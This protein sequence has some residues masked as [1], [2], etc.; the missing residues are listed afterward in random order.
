MRIGALFEGGRYSNFDARNAAGTFTFGGIDALPGRHPATYRTQRIGEVNTSFGDY[1]FGLYWQDDIRVNR[2]FSF[3]VGVRQ[4]DA[5]AHRDK[6]NVMPRWASHG[7]R[8]ATR[9]RIRGGYG[10]FYDWYDIGLYDQT[11]RVNGVAQRDL[12]ILNP[13]YPEP[14]LGPTR[15]VQPGGRIQA[16][17]GSGDALRPPGV[18]RRRAAVAHEP[19]A[20][21]NYQMLRGRNQMRAVNIN[22]GR[23]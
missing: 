18:D 7:R 1:Q 11:L 23:P 17:S 6:L 20:Q 19:H 2:H 10:M 12:L 3:S 16:A 13:G 9:R 5:V 22:A 8:R 14:V 4:G 21:V 15:D